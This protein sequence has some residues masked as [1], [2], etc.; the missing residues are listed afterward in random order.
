[1]CSS[2][3]VDPLLE[4]DDY[5][6]TAAMPTKG[7]TVQGEFDINDSTKKTSITYTGREGAEILEPYTTAGGVSSFGVPEA[8]K[9]GYHVSGW[10]AGTVQNG[11]TVYDETDEWIPG[12]Y[13]TYSQDGGTYYAKW[14]PNEQTLTFYEKDKTTLRGNVTVEYDQVGVTDGVI[15]YRSG[16]T[17][18]FI[19][20]IPMGQEC[21]ESNIVD[22]TTYHVT[23]DA[24]FYPWVKPTQKSIIIKAYIPDPEDSNAK[25]EVGTYTLDQAAQETFGLEI[26]YGDNINIVDA[27]PANPEP[28]ITYIT[29]SQIDDLMQGNPYTSVADGST[30]TP[31]AGLGNAAGKYELADT[32][33]TLYWEV[34]ESNSANPALNTNIIYVEYQ[35][36]I[37][38]EIFRATGAFVN[39][40]SAYEFRPATYNGDITYHTAT[41]QME[42]GDLEMQDV[43][44][45]EWY[46]EGRY[47]STYDFDAATA[48]VVA[49]F[50]FEG[51][52]L[53]EHLAGLHV[54][55]RILDLQEGAVAAHVLGYAAYG[56][57][58]NDL[59]RIVGL[60]IHVD[61]CRGGILH[62]LVVGRQTVPNE[63]GGDQRK[64]HDRRQQQRDGFLHCV[65]SPFQTQ[66]VVILHIGPNFMN[67]I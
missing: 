60:L 50:G 51:D 44:T 62:V 63:Q 40:G 36:A 29:Y 66:H 58:G 28:N 45:I 31:A 4:Y 49:P 1:M 26:R 61:R 53:Q 65:F 59:G 38:R 55:R 48:G 18:E 9:E 39:T 27:I 52:G 33:R 30:V 32:T 2:V 3:T 54:P 17:E 41:I 10:Y 25:I 19:G 43:Q 34:N 6:L 11:E 8:V 7:G 47:G 23:G 56:Q 57:G 22:F 46:V 64:H 42:D 67:N 20:W 15:T 13:A 5:T 35:G 24:S 12:F 14:A 37:V 21:T 16:N